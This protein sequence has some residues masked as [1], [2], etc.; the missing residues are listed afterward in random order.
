M[1]RQLVEALRG[2][3]QI[4]GGKELLRTTRYQLSVWRETGSTAG[5]IPPEDITIEGHIDITD[6]AEA[7]VLAGPDTLTLVLEDGR[8]LPFT[9]TSS[10]GSVIGRGGLRPPAD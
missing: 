8:I 5:S 6:I 2:V 9:L 7:V 3:G 10:R 4:Y 1:S